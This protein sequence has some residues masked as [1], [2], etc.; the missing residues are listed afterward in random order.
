VA[1]T[2]AVV[3]VEEGPKRAGLGAELAAELSE[4]MA[5][6]LVAPPRRVAAPNIPVPFSPPMEDY[7]RPGVE[8]II[9]A[10]RAVTYADF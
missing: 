6:Y 2:G 5:D 4:R 10:A 3:I 7:Y 1:K 9:E 8:D